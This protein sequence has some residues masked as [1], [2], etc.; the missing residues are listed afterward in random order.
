[1]THISTLKGHELRMTGNP[2]SLS[3]LLVYAFKIAVGDCVRTVSGEDV[4]VKVESVRVEGVYTIVTNEE[5]IVV[6]GIVASSFG[7]N[8][9]IGNLY[10]N[11]HR[12][13]YLLCPSVLSS[14]LIVTANEVSGQRPVILY[15]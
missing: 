10:Y 11:M 5:F 13:V 6:N 7:V 15:G 12:F 14:P 2:L 9:M 4:V 3:L 1:M 8:H